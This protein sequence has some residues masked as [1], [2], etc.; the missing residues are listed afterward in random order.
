MAAEKMKDRFRQR[1]D[2]LRRASGLEREHFDAVVMNLVARQKVD[3]VQGELT[4]RIALSDEEFK[5]LIE[6]DGVTY[7]YVIWPDKIP[8]T[9]AR[10]PPHPPNRWKNRNIPLSAEMAQWLHAM[11]RTERILRKMGSDD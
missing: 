4:E 1:I 3:L 8:A 10:V 9:Q 7:L 5:D 2:C 6:I 11:K